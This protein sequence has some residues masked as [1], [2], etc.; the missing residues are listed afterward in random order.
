MIS[1]LPCSDRKRSQ[2]FFS[3]SI[4]VFCFCNNY[5]CVISC[6]FNRIFRFKSLGNYHIIKLPLAHVIKFYYCFYFFD[7]FYIRCNQVI[8]LNRTDIYFISIRIFRNI[9]D[10]RYIRTIFDN[11]FACYGCG[12]TKNVGSLKFKCVHTV[13]KC[14][15]FRCDNT[16]ICTRKFI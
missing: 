10:C 13:C 12:I 6:F 16:C 1:M 2:N 11:H 8:P 4:C 14:S 15:I 3:D 9:L 5:C 7:F